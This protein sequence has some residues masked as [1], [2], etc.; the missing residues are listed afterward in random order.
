[1]DA[2]A[3]TGSA[4]TTYSIP[5]GLG[6]SHKRQNTDNS[7]KTVTASDEGVRLTH[8]HSREWSESDREH[9]MSWATYNGPDSP[10]ME[11]DEA[12]SPMIEQVA[13]AEK[14]ER[15]EMVQPVQVQ[16]RKLLKQG[17]PQHSELDGRELKR[18]SP[19]QDLKESEKEGR[20]SPTKP[21]LRRTSRISFREKMSNFGSSMSPKLG[22]SQK[23]EGSPKL[24]NKRDSHKSEEMIV[25]PSS[26]KIR[27][28]PRSDA[29]EEVSPLFTPIQSRPQFSPLTPED[30]KWAGQSSLEMWRH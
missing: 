25:S 24:E 28:W 20:K 8:N 1:M 6:R 7:A 29:R 23:Q 16:G 14:V 21:Q 12:F 4:A 9:V 10:L 3:R 17:S 22:S 19:Q 11:G 13:R 15:M 18:K 5:I 27:A 30:K 2:V 26:E